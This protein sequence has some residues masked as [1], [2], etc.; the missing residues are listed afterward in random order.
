MVFQNLRH[1]TA[2]FM[3][4]DNT[5]NRSA[6]CGHR[7]GRT[8]KFDLLLQTAMLH[9]S[10]VLSAGIRNGF[11]AQGF[12]PT[13]CVCIIASFGDFQALVP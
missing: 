10:T 12:L 2:K 13:F 4:V 3:A 11:I 5:R 9:I 7:D 1:L 8:R 6:I